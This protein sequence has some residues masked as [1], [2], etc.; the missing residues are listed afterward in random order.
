MACSISR[1]EACQKKPEKKKEN[2]I[3]LTLTMLNLYASN[4]QS[5]FINNHIVIKQ[6]KALTLFRKIQGPSNCPYVEL[7]NNQP[8][9][10]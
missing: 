8:A 3:P 4:I 5:Y 1:I 6:I 7:S 9:T 10:T 2:E